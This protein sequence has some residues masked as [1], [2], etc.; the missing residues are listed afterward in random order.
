MIILLFVVTATLIVSALCSLCEAILYSTSIAAL[1]SAKTKDRRRKAAEQFLGFKKQISRPIAAILIINTLANTAGA[2]YTGMYAAKHYP[3]SWLPMFSI[4]LTLAI[5]IFGEIVPKNI[6]VT[7]NKNLWS[8]IVTPLRFMGVLLA[9]LI[10][11]TE[12]ISQYFQK[13]HRQSSITVEEILALVKLSAHQGDITQD[14]SH[15][16]RN[17]I[18]QD[19]KHVRTIMTPRSVMFALN[20]ESTVDESFKLIMEK[21][22][23]RVPIYQDSTDNIIGYVMLFDLGNA[24]LENQGQEVIRKFCRSISFVPETADCLVTLTMFLKQ[25]KHLAIVV[26]EYDG[27][28]GLITLEDLVET[29]LGAEIV[30]EK[31]RFV[32]LQTVAR[33]HTPQTIK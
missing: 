21:G 20:G 15:L 7:Y 14:E 2:A 8:Y 11:L 16:V 10:A 17:I 25:R 13:S 33:K 32:D 1:E 19:K 29:M 9:P 6:G 27:I 3:E 30:D 18:N 24:K 5:L 22:F 26:D 31:D 23:S 28:A 12:K 4:A